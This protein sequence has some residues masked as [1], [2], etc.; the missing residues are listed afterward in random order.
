MPKNNS[1]KIWYSAKYVTEKNNTIDFVGFN[2]NLGIL[3]SGSLAVLRVQFIP[4]L[5]TTFLASPVLIKK[6]GRFQLSS[7]SKQLPILL[8]ACT[9]YV[10]AF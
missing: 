3:G 5:L 7:N 8:A 10:G 1:W 6:H 9:L 4:L 2:F